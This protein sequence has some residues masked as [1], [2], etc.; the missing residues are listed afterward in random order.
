MWKERVKSVKFWVAIVVVI[1]AVAGGYY[2]YQQQKAASAKGIYT[3]GKVERGNVGIIVSATGTI[4]PVNY[5][6]V[7]TN[8]AGLLERVLVSENDQVQQGQVIA[9]IDERS[10]KA[11]MEDAL[12]TLN[13]NR[14]DYERYTTLYDQ[15]AVSQQSF[16]TAKAAY[17]SAQAAY[18]RAVSN[19]SDATITAPMSG[20]IIGTP[21]KA[22]QTI[23]TGLSSQ[24][25]IATIADLSNLEIYLAVDET[26]ISSIAVGQN[27]SFT[28]DAYT[29]K[30][31]N[32]TVK[33]ISRGT[34]GNMGTTSSTVVY[35]TVKVQISGN[36]TNELLPTMTARASIHGREA[37]DALVVPLTA[38]RSD[39]AGEYVYKIENGKPVRTTVKTGITG[40]TSVQITSGLSEGDEIVISGN[41]TASTTSS[42]SGPRMPF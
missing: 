20:T 9:Y 15:D 34:K 41:V 39:K 7:S 40:D 33:S 17:L 11:V 31:F 23:S 29:D 36:E 27:V 5:V 3:T 35:Y 1:A 26:D 22:G 14:A 28:V 18:D 42:S 6:D 30:T 38:I 37:K 8:V 24:M 25:I 16:D 13:K 21:L 10:L 2:Y 12:A 4:N 19:L 32:G